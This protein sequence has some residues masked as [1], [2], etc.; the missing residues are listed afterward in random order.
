MT[1]R[2]SVMPAEWP[3]KPKMAM[4]DMKL[5]CF[6]VV[7]QC[8]GLTPALVRLDFNSAAV[9]PVESC[10]VDFEGSLQRGDHVVVWYSQ[11]G[12]ARVKVCTTNIQ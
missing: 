4:L 6:G 12:G 9:I 1:K 11:T 5:M 7:E 10:L 3:K 2:C 8:D